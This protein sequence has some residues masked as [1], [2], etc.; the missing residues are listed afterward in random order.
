MKVSQWRSLI[1]LLTCIGSAYGSAPQ[2]LVATN[3][4]TV[5]MG[6]TFAD[7][8]PNNWSQTVVFEI[9]NNLP[10]DTTKPI[11]LV[12]AGY[13]AT[14]FLFVD[15]CSGS[16]LAAKRSCRLAVTL[17][18]KVVGEK[19]L[20]IAITGFGKSV[21]K[22]PNIK[23]KSFQ[24]VT[25]TVD[26]RVTHGVPATPLLNLAHPFAF[27]FFNRS[28]AAIANPSV[29]LTAFSGTINTDSNS[30]NTAALAVGANCMVTGTYTPTSAN[31]SVQA[32]FA[33][34]GGDNVTAV[35][36]GQPEIIA[37]QAG[38]DTLPS[39]D[40]IVAAGITTV[41]LAFLVFDLNHPGKLVATF[42]AINVGDIYELRQK[43]IHVNLSI[44]GASSSLADTTVNFHE[45][46]TAASDPQ[47]FTQTF[48]QSMQD[49]QAIYGTD[50]F[51]ID[52]EQGLNEGGTFADPMGDIRVLADIIN[53]FNA[54]RPEQTISAV[55]QVANVS[56]TPAFNNT[57][58][59]YSAWLMLVPDA[60]SYAGAQ[61]YNAGS[62][63]GI[64]CGLYDP[65]YANSSP[66][67]SVAIIIDMLMNWPSHCPQGQASGFQP[68]IA[69]LTAS[70]VSIGYP[71]ANSNGISDGTPAGNPVVIKQAIKCLQTGATGCGS[72]IPPT[73]FQINKVFFWD[74]THDA[75]NGFAF[76][77]SMYKCLF[78]QNCA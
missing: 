4:I 75:N 49:M 35:T 63:Y 50:G 74:M 70:Q 68:Y 55:P 57:F 5:T 17:T 19:T 37:Y 62:F 38:W 6:S 31:G 15:E 56:A 69:K 66:D 61:M 33:Y 39:A 78:Q 22:L 11:Q 16:T 12:K 13:P 9:T 2:T 43:G 10:W 41:N 54:I 25:R 60:I 64:D 46:L 8:I 29:T 14:E 76:S 48:I 58:G 44:G 18:P 40:A 45:V 1:I 34:G 7:P 21:V 3:A 28:T 30:C 77:T 72:Y 47:T 71:A 51:D 52:I 53:G 23:T 59:N 65:N 73:T 26:A 42:S 20:E 27:S 67:P 24:G 32:S 36:P